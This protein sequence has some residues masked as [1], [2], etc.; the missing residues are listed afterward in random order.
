MI[1][2][3]LRNPETKQPFGIL[4]A[5]QAPDGLRFGWSVTHSLDKFNKA[6]GEKIAMNRL[7]AHSPGDDLIVP[8]VLFETMEKFVTR[9]QKYFH[10]ET[11]SY[12]MDGWVLKAKK[13]R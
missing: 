7:A 13:P 5:I 12:V 10:Q 8:S 1:K 3:F 4:M 6:K 11:A 9:A 2:Q